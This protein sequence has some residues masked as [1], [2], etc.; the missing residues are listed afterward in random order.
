MGT[1]AQHYDQEQN[2]KAYWQSVQLKAK[3]QLKE[4]REIWGILSLSHMG[5]I[6][7]VREIQ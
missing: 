1:R 6:T 4:F 5:D 3:I 7:K 2:V